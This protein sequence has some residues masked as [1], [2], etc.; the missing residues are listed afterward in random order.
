MKHL[1]DGVIKAGDTDVIGN[2]DA[3]FLQCLVNARSGLMGGNKKC[4][5]SFATAKQGL[6]GE[7]SQLTV[8]RSD[9]AEVWFQA[10]FFH[11]LEVAARTTRKP[12]QSLVADIPDISVALRNQIT[13][14]V[15]GSA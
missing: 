3:G 8:F 4:G 7:V 13:R 14:D 15:G 1:S 11:S 9:F 10:G 5:G 2:S 12:W 6:G